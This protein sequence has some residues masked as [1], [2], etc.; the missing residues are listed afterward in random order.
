MCSI[1]T[2]IRKAPPLSIYF[3][4]DY[5]IRNH[6]EIFESHMFLTTDKAV[7]SQ[8][9]IPEVSFA[10]GL[11]ESKSVNGTFASRD[12]RIHALR[13]FNSCILGHKGRR[14]GK[15]DVGCFLGTFQAD[16]EDGENIGTLIMA[17]RTLQPWIFIDFARQ[18]SGFVVEFSARTRRAAAVTPHFFQN[19]R[20]PHFHF[21]YEK[22]EGT[23]DECLLQH[24][25]YDRMN[26]VNKF[27]IR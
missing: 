5:A 18:L 15:S 14:P 27:K 20:Y 4:N 1:K 7:Q 3:E 23:D 22:R 19:N 24:Y 13:Q 6:L 21:L 9:F 17:Y 8:S 11:V 25:L 10:A 2:D 16:I 26:R 12:T